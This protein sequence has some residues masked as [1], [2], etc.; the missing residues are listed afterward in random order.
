MMKKGIIAVDFDGTVVENTFPNIGAELPGAVDTLKKLQQSGW[1][2]IIWTCRAG[3]KIK[4]AVRWLSE[5][6]FIP[7]KVN[8]NVDGITD[9]AK[10]KIFASYYIDDRNFPPF[11]GWESVRKYFLEEQ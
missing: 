9:Y 2:I 6:G 7:D 1:L 5:K 10:R 4:D 11:M 3:D 8:E